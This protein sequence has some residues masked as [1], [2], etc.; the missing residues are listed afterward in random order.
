M[1]LNNRGISI[2]EIVL[3]FT[4]IMMITIGLIDIVMNYRNKASLSLRKLDMDTFKNTLT[5]DI[6]DDIL[7]LGIKEINTDGECTTIQ[8]LKR[9]IN[10]VFQDGSEKAFGTS[11][12]NPNDENSVRNKYLYYD[13]EKYALHDEL[14][15]KVPVGRNILD[16]QSIT[17]ED[18][19]LLSTDSIILEDGTVIQ[20]Y[21]ID[22]FISHIDFDQDFGIHIVATT[23]AI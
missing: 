2:I 11:A 3:T 10:I 8:G 22:V 13:G 6:Q 7:T 16:F 17:V 19:N 21:T 9:C 15:D 14:P 23:E 18:N 1:K 5:K 20:I 4:L 12:I